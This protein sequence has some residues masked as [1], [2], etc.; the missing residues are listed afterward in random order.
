MSTVHN[1]PFCS[2]DEMRDCNISWSGTK[3]IKSFHEKLDNFGMP[4]RKN[5]FTKELP[6]NTEARC[7]QIRMSVYDSQLCKGPEVSVIVRLPDVLPPSN[8]HV[9]VSVW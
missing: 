1:Q 4:I 8:V 3:S 9:N 7:V 5:D 2:I 6:N